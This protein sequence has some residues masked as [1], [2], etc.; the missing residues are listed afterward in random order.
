MKRI[1]F[2]INGLI[3]FVLWYVLYYADNYIDF[4]DFDFPIKYIA[5]RA[6]IMNFIGTSIL[7]FVSFIINKNAMKLSNIL[8]T[9]AVATLLERIIVPLYDVIKLNSEFFNKGHHSYIWDAKYISIQIISLL[10][11]IL[12]LFTVKK[13]KKIIQQK[14]KV[15]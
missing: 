6:F 5:L 11:V 13:I 4:I 3:L 14:K 10:I 7:Y 2:I 1:L 12:L 15:A 8:L 9:F